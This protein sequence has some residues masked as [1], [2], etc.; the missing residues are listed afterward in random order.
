M[1]DLV[2]RLRDMARNRYNAVGDLL[3]EAATALEAQ[4]IQQWYRDALDEIDELLAA[5]KKSESKIAQLTAA[6]EAAR[7]DVARMDWLDTQRGDDVRGSYPSEPELAGH[8]WSVEGQCYD[9]RAAI[10]AAMESGSET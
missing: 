2:E 3:T 1:T 10:D 6:L 7:E 5:A 9:V 8:Y 4:K